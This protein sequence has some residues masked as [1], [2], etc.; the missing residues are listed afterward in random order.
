MNRLALLL[1]LALPFVGCDSNGP[2][3]RSCENDSLVVETEDL[4]V[5]TSPARA[6]A[7]DLVRLS[8]VG[9]LENGTEFDSDTNITVQLQ[10]FDVV[11]FR[12]GVAGM[13]IGGTRRITVPP[14]KGYRT[15]RVTQRVDEEEVELI[16]PCSVLVFEVELIDILS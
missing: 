11:G 1:V 12:E 13:R 5:G 15:L 14:Y 9:R 4:V 7:T 3:I 16:P 2:T 6:D 8:Y 10:A